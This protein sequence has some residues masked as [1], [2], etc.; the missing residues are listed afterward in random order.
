MEEDISDNLL[1][2]FR[3]YDSSGGNYFAE[4]CFTFKN[5]KCAYIMFRKFGNA[6]DDFCDTVFHQG[7]VIEFFGVEIEESEV[8]NSR[9]SHTFERMAKFR[10]KNDNDRNDSKTENL[11]KKIRRAL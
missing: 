10:L 3:V 7:F 6:I 11:L 8:G 9:F 4:F 5:N 2:G 1:A